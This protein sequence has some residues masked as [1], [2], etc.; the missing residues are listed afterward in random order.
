MVNLNNDYEVDDRYKAFEDH[1]SGVLVS[2]AGPGTGK[3]FSLLKRIN[4]LIN[5]RS[6]PS[7]EICYLTFIRDI[8]DAF[9]TDFNLEFG[10]QPD[11]GDIP[12]I[13]TLHSLA[14]RLIRNR[15]FSINYDGEIYFT[16]IAPK[17]DTFESRI[18]LSD[19]IGIVNNE[20]LNTIAKIR[21]HLLQTKEAWRNRIDPE[22]LGGLEQLAYNGYLELAQRYRLIDWDHTI[23]VA[24]E[25]Y[26]IEE[27]RQRWLTQIKHLLI[28]EFQDFNKAEQQFIS[29]IVS[30][31]SSAVIVGDDDQSIFSGRGG[32]P[33]GIRILFNSTDANQVSL[34]KCRRSKSDVLA[35][36]NT[37]LRTMNPNPREMLPHF[38][39]GTMQ[40]LRFKSSKA[41]INYLIDFLRNFQDTL[42]DEPLPKDGAVCLFPTKKSLGFYFE[43]LSQ[44]VPCYTTKLD[45]NQAR[46]KLTQALNLCVRPYQRFTER[47][48]LDFF[49][50]IKPAH[51]KKI[52]RLIFDRDIS[53]TDACQVMLDE[54]KFSGASISNAERFIT[55]CQALSSQN[56]HEIANAIS[57]WA[58]ICVDDFES[59]LDTFF[60][61]LDD[62]EQEASISDFCDLALPSTAM[63]PIDSKAIEFL[64]IHGAK[65]L[66]KNTVIMPGLE[67]SWLPGACES[68]ELKEKQRLFYVAITRATDYVLITHPVNRSRGDPL[69]YPAEGRSEVSRFT[70]DAGIDTQYQH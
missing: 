36:V 14:C 46:I 1:E 17:P 25:L 41:E 2:L 70:L 32:S 58:E 67:D 5:N 13:S 9:Q 56:S 65:G 27:N 24:T 29:E 68:P 59:L 28:D 12:R 60:A 35:H 23:P 18:F 3:T 22:T 33:E 50:D 54:G 43:A 55:I 21:N 39:G 6:I 11:F 66:T 30:N 61:N 15:G 20:N 53:P 16:N 57:G 47:L 63:P 37:F 52:V 64:T 34:T 69:N 44:Q 49:T 8:A 48:L 38:Y 19:L 42:P 62:H 40:S 4:T 26:A 45:D 7:S 10:E 51:K 31:I